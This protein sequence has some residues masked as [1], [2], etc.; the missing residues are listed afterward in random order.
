[1]WN[2]PYF[3]ANLSEVSVLSYRLSGLC[4]ELQSAALATYQFDRAAVLRSHNRITSYLRSDQPEPP[5]ASADF[6][7]QL[8][9]FV[10][11]TNSHVRNEN[12]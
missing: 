5:R 7:S 11:E 12:I 4:G 2:H 8:F 1:M 3:A 9:V 10:L 6:E